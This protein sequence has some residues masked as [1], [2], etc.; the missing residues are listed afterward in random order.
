MIIRKYTEQDRNGL[1]DLWAESF[2]SDRSHNEP[3]KMIAA[4]LLIDDQIFVAEEGGNIYGACMAGYDGHRGWLYAV[5][6]SPTK[7]RLGIGQSLVAKAMKSLK[8]L[9]C[10]KVNLQVRAS[11][12]EIK[13]FYESI[14]FDEEERISMGIF[15]E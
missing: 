15:L 14:G 13:A 3:S 7:R 8:K 9:G 12:H 5:A 10:I 6:V 4:K 11:N 2:P 1:I